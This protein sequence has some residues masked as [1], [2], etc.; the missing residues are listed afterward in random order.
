MKTYLVTGGA[1]FIGSHLCHALLKAGQAV[2]VLDNFSTGKRE[3]LAALPADGR[4]EILEGDVAEAELCRR[5]VRGVEAVFHQAALGS[6]PKSILEPAPTHRANATGT[7][8]MLE[9]ARLEGVARFV[10]A[11]SSSV[12]GD[13]PTLPK[14]ETMPLNPLSP[15]A[16]SKAAGELYGQVYARL[17]RLPVCI[18]R[19]FNVFG[20]RQDP[21]SQYAAVIPRFYSALLHNQPPEIYGDGQQTRDFTY[22]ED[23]VQANLACLEAPPQAFGQPINIAGGKQFSLLDLFEE[24]RRSV[25]SALAPQF[26][27][28]RP[29][30]IKHSLASIDRARAWLRFS[31]RYTVSEGLSRCAAWYRENLR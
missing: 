11:S 22:V 5:A 27:A 2:R 20:P 4:L 8:H 28:P 26:A 6:V 14:V 17:H 30:D 9:A 13:A 31:P 25:G 16:V 10:F 29:G 7:L 1:G 24:I 3:N 21:D 19:Y 18:L 23:C 15:Y 12:Y